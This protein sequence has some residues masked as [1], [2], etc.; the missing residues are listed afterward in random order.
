MAEQ[1]RELKQ[2]RAEQGTWAK[3]QK[4]LETQVGTRGL[5]GPC[6]SGIM[7]LMCGRQGRLRPSRRV[8]RGA[9]GA[10]GD[11]RWAKDLE[12]A[13]CVWRK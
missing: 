9:T 2:L 5:A 1:A 3:T 8:C 12:E 13:G 7:S 6:G 4:A 10:R 11:E